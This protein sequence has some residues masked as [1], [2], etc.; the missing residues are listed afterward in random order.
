MFLHHPAIFRYFSYVSQEKHIN[1]VKI[2]L[3]ENACNLYNLL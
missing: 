3:R 2:S 1:N